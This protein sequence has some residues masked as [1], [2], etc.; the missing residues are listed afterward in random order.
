MCHGISVW[1][2][3]FA[4]LHRE[5]T[6]TL[7]SKFKSEGVLVN[8]NDI[9]GIIA[10]I[11]NKRK[12]TER[13]PSNFIQETSCFLTVGKKDLFDYVDNEWSVDNDINL[14]ENIFF[15]A[16]CLVPFITNKNDAIVNEIDR[17]TT[18]MVYFALSFLITNW[19][20]FKM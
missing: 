19:Q 18:W 7:K 12:Q 13:Q 4:E 16:C 11:F 3:Q 15:V 17:Q 9:L 1:C 14:R 6:W 2:L 10:I 20:F 5:Q 8:T